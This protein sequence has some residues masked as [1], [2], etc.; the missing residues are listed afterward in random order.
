M[1]ASYA[2][3]CAFI[4]EHEGRQ[5]GGTIRA[6]LS[7][8]CSWHLINHAPWYGDDSW[9]HL[10]RI[11]ANKEGTKHKLPLHA[12]VSIEHLSCLRRSLDLSNPFHAAVWA[13]ALVTFWGCRRLGETTLTVAVALDP[14]YHVLRST[15]YVYYCV[16]HVMFLIVSLEFRFAYCVMVLALRALIF[17]GQ[18]QLKSSGPLSF[19]LRAV[20]ATLY[21]QSQPSRIILTSIH[22]SPPLP[23]FS[24]TSPHLANPKIFSRTNFFHLSLKSG[25]PPCSPMSWVTA[26][27]LVVL[28]SYFSQEFLQ[29]SLPLLGAGH[30]LPSYFIGAAWTKSYLC[31]LQKLTTKHILTISP[32]FSKTFVLLIKSL[33]P[34][35]IVLLSDSPCNTSAYFTLFLN[36]SHKIVI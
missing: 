23:L 7:S 17:L 9:V 19:S 5:A 29:K 21:V 2:L 4:G 28:W 10:A 13:V 18:N 25:P 20:M 35:L 3:L 24:P 8:I 6:W 30:P 33:P 32:L 11:S 16:L 12:P 34:Y 22:Q 36:R 1:P 31:P 15:K 26:S 27:V 14:K